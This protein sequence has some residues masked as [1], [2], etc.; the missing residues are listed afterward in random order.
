MKLLNYKRKT[1]AQVLI[2][3]LP[4]IFGKWSKATHFEQCIKSQQIHF[5]AYLKR[6][7]PRLTNWSPRTHERRVAYIQHVTNFWG[8]TWENRK[9]LCARNTKWI[10]ANPI[11][12]NRR[13][14]IWRFSQNRNGITGTSQPK[15]IYHTVFDWQ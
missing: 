7:K 2:Y 6:Q 15:N 5:I 12:K 4:N 10:R 9:F 13:T 3:R 14:D 1:G 11:H 8:S